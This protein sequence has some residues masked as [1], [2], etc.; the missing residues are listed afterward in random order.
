MILAFEGAPGTGKSTTAAALTAQG[1][2]V[3]REV[4]QLFA[5]PHPEPVDWNYERHNARWEMAQLKAAQGT[6]AVLDGDPFHPIWFPWIYPDAGFAPVSTAAQFYSDRLVARQ[7][8]FPDLY[9]FMHIAEPER[10]KRMLARERAQGVADETAKRKIRHYARMVGPQRRYFTALNE[11]FPGW[12]LF[13][14]T[15][16][17]ESSIAVIRDAAQQP[18]AERD[19]VEVLQFMVEWLATNSPQA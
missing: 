17:L 4:N 19:G 9:V 11:R 13:V 2:F 16:S 15:S 10:R 5:R 3:V 12:V 1:A 8:A 6:L 18:A 7:L 14:E